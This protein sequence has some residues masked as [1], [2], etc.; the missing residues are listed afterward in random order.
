MPFSDHDIAAL[1]AFR[2]RLHAA[3]EASGEEEATAEM[4][5]SYLE[6]IG[7]SAILSGLGG[8]GVAAV[9]EGPTAGPT[10]LL[11]AELDGL[12]IEEI[13]DLPYRSRVAGRAHMCGHDGHMAALMGC[14]LALAADPPKRGRVVL[15][16]QPAEEDGSGAA[17][18]MADPRFATIAPDYAFSWHNMPGFPFGEGQMRVGPMFCASAGMQ[19][20]LRGRTAHASQPEN[21]VSP[22]QCLA[23]LIQGIADLGRGG[24]L[25]AGYRLV[26]ITHARLGEATFGVAPGAAELRATLRAV[27]PAEMEA[28]AQEAQDLVQMAAA[29][30]GLAAEIHWHDRFASSLNDPDASTILR[31]T[32]RAQGIACHELPTPFRPS[33]DFGRFGAEARAAMVVIGAG[34]DVAMLHNPDY[35]FPDDLIAV[36]ARVLL[37]AARRLVG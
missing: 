23:A 15:M 17:A 6:K 12:K 2:H 7:G 18:V 8:H 20:L 10:V 37:G 9:F 24:A 5:R 19:I 13:G 11:R 4:V 28:L 27:M 35:D 22:A 21:G 25:D 29:K 14:A 30:A 34:D 16:F 32:M 36:G 33:E 26:T 31:E 1:R 3:P